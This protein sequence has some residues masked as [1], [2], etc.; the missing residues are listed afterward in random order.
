[1]RKERKHYTAKEKGAILRRHLLDKVQVSDLR[2][3]LSLKAVRNKNA[4]LV[5]GSS[6]HAGFISGSFCYKLWKRLLKDPYPILGKTE[7]TA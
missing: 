7:T 6:L 3:E 1:M 4:S 2:E 5:V